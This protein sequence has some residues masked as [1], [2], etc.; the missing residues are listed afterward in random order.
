MRFFLGEL[1]RELF[2]SFIIYTNLKPEVH[3]H[4]YLTII[5]L[6]CRECMLRFQ[7]YKIKIKKYVNF[8]FFFF[9]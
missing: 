9:G 2:L 5:V 8:F 6:R 7:T 3:Y 1:L 4:R